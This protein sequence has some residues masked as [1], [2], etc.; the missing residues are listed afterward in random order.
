MASV[1]SPTPHPGALASTSGEQNGD[2]WVAL[3][4]SK[5]T[6]QASMNSVP[7]AAPT[8]ASEAWTAWKCTST[9]ATAV[10]PALLACRAMAPT[11]QTS[12]R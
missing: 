8:P 2:L 5:P 6:P 4:V 7:T 1:C 3:T 9:P 11:A 12:M 10:G